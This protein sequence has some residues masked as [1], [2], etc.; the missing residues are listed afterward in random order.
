MLA[1]VLEEENIYKVSEISGETGSPRPSPAADMDPEA[2]RLL[3]QVKS[4]LSN[5]RIAARGLETL[6][7]RW[8]LGT[9]VW[10]PEKVI[11]Y[12]EF[13]WERV[14]RL[15]AR[16]SEEGAV[17][18]L[19]GLAGT[20]RGRPGEGEGAQAAAWT[21]GRTPRARRR[22]CSAACAA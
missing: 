3:K 10:E 8:T 5:A 21:T 12:A 18:G 13:L 16:V 20:G 22:S 4:E 19:E 14:P 11:Y 17:P 6:P 1:R 9:K 15:E 2:R 7:V